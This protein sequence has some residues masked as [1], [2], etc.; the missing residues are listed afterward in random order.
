MN[1]KYDLIIVGGGVLGAFHA[2]HAL[3][4]GLSV[5]LIEKDRQPQHATVRNFG[6]VVPSG[7]NTKWQ[8][9]GRESLR[10]YKE[11]QNR[12]DISVRQNG[13]VYLASNEAEV[14]LLEELRCINQKNGYASQ[15]L[16]T[17]ECLERYP[18]LKPEYVKAGLFFP[19]EVT[20]EP[21]VMIGRLLAYLVGDKGL[22]YYNDT[23]VLNCTALTDG[24]EV[25]TAAGAI[26]YAAKVIICSGAAFK[27]LYP[28]LFA[29][30]DLEVSKLQ[31]L[32]TVPQKGYVLNGSILTGLSIR[33]Y[34]AFYECSSFANIQ[35][36]EDPGSFEKK[37]GIHIL[38][39][40]A[41]DGS[42]II[43]DSHEYADAANADALGF[44]LR[45]DIDAF[46]IAEAKKII[47]LPSYEIQHRWYGIY[48]QCKRQDLFQH[49]IDKHIHI[50]TGIGGKGMTGSAG[51]SKEHIK[52]VFNLNEK[53]EQY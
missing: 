27:T 11:I 16:S 19:E 18:G 36:K 49:T 41:T 39:K 38:F 44:D 17:R 7:M 9:Y 3:E 31:M 8:L 1:K 37:W 32:Q 29:G 52:Q 30:S 4:L 42:V 6:Q 22:D 40:Q 35:S 28:A 47:E 50:V 45:A 10:I 2:Y 53:Y 21:R 48:S 13:S 23:L 24:V 20:V 26:F 14:Q 43:G 5:A 25:H 15:L 33:R 46:M 34:E 12:F 51:F